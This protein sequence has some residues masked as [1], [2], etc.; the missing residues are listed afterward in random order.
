MPTF[1]AQ[2]PSAVGRRVLGAA[3][4][5]T[6]LLGVLGDDRFLAASGLFGV[7]WWAWD[8]LWDQ[9]APFANWLSRVLTGV[10]DVQEPPDLTLD[11]TVRLLE[12]RLASA[13][14]TR[15]VQIEAAVRLAEI[16]LLNK[17]DPAKARE[18]IELVK[19]RWPDSAEL[20]F[21]EETHQLGTPEK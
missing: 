10:A 13:V 14:A 5:I 9:V 11:D 17:H 3:T 7:A 15:H 1:G 19:A 8:F 21:F 4:I 12:G 16:Y 6:L 2:S 18:V 20:R